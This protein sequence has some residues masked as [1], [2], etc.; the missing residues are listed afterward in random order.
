MRIVIPILVVL[1]VIYS[2]ARLQ[3]SKQIEQKVEVLTGYYMPV[4]NKADL[5]ARVYNLSQ[6]SKK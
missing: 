6:R 4:A 2:V 5:S 3:Q 1:S